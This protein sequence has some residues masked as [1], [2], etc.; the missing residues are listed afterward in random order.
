MESVLKK[1]SCFGE[2][3]IP[4][5]SAIRDFDSPH[6]Q[7]RWYNILHPKGKS[8]GKVGQIKLYLEYFDKRVSSVPTNFRRLFGWNPVEGGFN[9]RSIPREWR[10]KFEELG[11]RPS[12]LKRNNR[13]S[14][15]VL[16]IMKESVIHDTDVTTSSS[17]SVIPTFRALQI[18]NRVSSDATPQKLKSP[19]TNTDLINSNLKK[20]SIDDA[21]RHAMT[22][23]NNTIKETNVEDE[24]NWSDLTDSQ[25]DEKSNSEST[26]SPQET[27]THS[28]RDSYEANNESV[29]VISYYYNYNYSS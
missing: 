8:D 7:L 13:F 6:Y 19:L 12:D 15:Y 1:A 17:S 25:S 27:S 9:V 26:G 20:H 24:E 2:V 3:T 4:L 23:H 29:S 16:D 10:L 14:A 11:I 5:R 18:G 28:S 22:M 21:L